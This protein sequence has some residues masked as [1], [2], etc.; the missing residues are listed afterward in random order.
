MNYGTLNESGEQM[1]KA[2]QSGARVDIG[3]DMLAA[4][5]DIIREAFLLDV[6]Q[7]LKDSPS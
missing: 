5:H 1:V 3:A 7:M 4:E 2:F 6:F